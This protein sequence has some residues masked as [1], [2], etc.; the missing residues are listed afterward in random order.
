MENKNFMV[1][2]NE[3][4][5]ENW[6]S[7]L[8]DEKGKF[9]LSCNKTVV[10]FSNKSDEEIKY[11]LIEKSKEKVCGRFKT[12]QLNRPLEQKLD[13]NK[14]PFNTSITKKFAVALFLV[15]G[16]LLFS[17]KDYSNKSIEVKGE[18]EYS[19]HVVG[20]M[21]Q[22]PNSFVE[23]DSLIE[24][25]FSYTQG[26]IVGKLDYATP[27]LKDS[28]YINDEDMLTG[29]VCIMPNEEDSTVVKN[30]LIQYDTTNTNKNIINNYNNAIN[31]KLTSGVS[32]NLNVF[33]NPSNGSFTVQFEVKK[34]MPLT[35]SVFDLNGALIKTISSNTFHNTG[36]Y[37]LTTTINEFVNGIYFVS[38]AGGGKVETKKMVL[39]K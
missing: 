25:C 27:E 38:I 28:I 9:C 16:S 12:Q 36:K 1:Q 20:L 17:C 29:D 13:L 7:M 4:C 6:N 33:P 30:N 10:D 5:H 19:D 24:E 26:E 2:I 21:M 11:I 14:L 22:P 34:A 18:V 35:I 3:P 15:F 8:P 23:K 31:E 37:E 39:S 32:K